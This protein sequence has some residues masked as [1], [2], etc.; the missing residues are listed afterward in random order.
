MKKILFSAIACLLLSSTA[1]AQE[2]G[3][4]T[5][6]VP[7]VAEIAQ[8]RLAE[9]ITDEQF[10][11]AAK[12]TMTYLCSIDGFIRRNLSKDETGLWTDYVEWTDAKIAQ[13]A[14]ENAMKREDMMTFMT[15]IDPDSISMKYSDILPLSK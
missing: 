8:F 15:T 10:L 11:I 4:K 5:S 14:A 12:D 9:N 2:C 13:S 3:T 6:Q 1:N 7:A